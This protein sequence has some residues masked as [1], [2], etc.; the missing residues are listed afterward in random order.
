MPGLSLG[1]R[2]LQPISL[3]L[4]LSLAVCICGCIGKGFSFPGFGSKAEEPGTA[5]VELERPLESTPVS[6]ADLPHVAQNQINLGEGHAELSYEQLEAELNTASSGVLNVSRSQSESSD[7]LDAAFLIQEKMADSGKAES[8][9]IGTY[10]ELVSSVDAGESNLDALRSSLEELNSTTTKLDSLPSST[11]QSQPAEEFV[12]QLETSV[13]DVASI[14]PVITPAQ[15][16]VT[17][18]EPMASGDEEFPWATGTANA[19]PVVDRMKDILSKATNVAHE[20]S[21]I[22]SQKIAETAHTVIQKTQSVLTPE[23]VTAEQVLAEMK[24]RQEVRDQRRTAAVVIQPQPGTA[25]VESELPAPVVIDL[26][27]DW[28]NTPQPAPEKKD[29]IAQF[30]EST[31]LANRPAQLPVITPAGQEPV[32]QPK[33]QNSTPQPPVLGS[34]QTPRKPETIPRDE[35][36]VRLG[37]VPV[38]DDAHQMISGT[39]DSVPMLGA[40][41]LE[42]SSAP[43]IVLGDSGSKAPLLIAP[44]GAASAEQDDN[45]DEFAASFGDATVTTAPVIRESPLLIDEDEL[46]QNAQLENAVSST[47]LTIIVCGTAFLAMLLARWRR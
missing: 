9:K 15:T 42:T 19:A 37:D 29:S 17:E 5:E 32:S 7:E 45:F 20:G 41:Q 34:P 36:I 44:G 22:G 12:V 2:Q 27:R 25:L 11:E 26:S 14:E 47:H 39:A 33:L 1:R 13:A 46:K 10:Q 28:I 30:A 21:R 24:A 23:E 43:P 6:S 40:P 31:V 16:S 38:E 18:A 35:D 4:S 3:A 8:T